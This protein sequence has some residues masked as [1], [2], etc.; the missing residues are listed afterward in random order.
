M[1][2]CF[3]L[4]E[5]KNKR[6]IA[7]SLVLKQHLS[8]T[9]QKSL[10]SLQRP[11]IFSRICDKNMT[12]LLRIK[13]QLTYR[14]FADQFFTQIVNHH[15]SRS[16]YLAALGLHFLWKEGE[17]KSIKIIGIWLEK[18]LGGLIKKKDQLLLIN[19]P[20]SLNLGLITGLHSLHFERR[21]KERMK[22]HK[23]ELSV[24]DTAIEHE[25]HTLAVLEQIRFWF[26]EVGDVVCYLHLVI[27]GK[28]VLSLHRVSYTNGIIK[29]TLIYFTNDMLA[30]RRNNELDNFIV[31]QLTQG[32]NQRMLSP[33]N[34]NHYHYSN[35]QH[36]ERNDR[37]VSPNRIANTRRPMIAPIR[38][39]TSPVPAP[40]KQKQTNRDQFCSNENHRNKKAE[41]LIHI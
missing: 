29:N 5:E 36:A 34:H 41:Y 2:R 18:N 37:N 22:I 6:N 26:G 39:A 15:H 38:S 35:A 30:Q 33:M 20:L 25:C 24:E 14:L 28:D 13:T 1:W 21:I 23:G 16:I 11:I 31:S 19:H 4:F 10:L 7:P 3:R 9:Q 12:N 32:N 40:Q 27:F 17:V 8:E